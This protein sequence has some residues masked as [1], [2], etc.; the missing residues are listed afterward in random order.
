MYF[1]SLVAA[2]FLN[3][4]VLIYGPGGPAPVMKE[5]ALKF[6][7]KTKEKVVVTAGPTPSWFK[8]ARKDADL[9]FSGNT[10]MMDGF[11]KRIPSLN[12]EDLVVLNARP[13]GIIV[14]PN[15]P[16]NIKS[17]EDILK[18]N[19][20]VMV[21]DG[22]GQVGL[23]EDMALKDGKRE[24][25]VKLRKNIKVYAKNSKIAIDEWNNNP[26]I[27]TLIIWSHWAKVLGDKALFVED[28][29]A[30]VYCTAEIIPT[31]KGLQNK[32]ALEFVKFIQSKEAQKI[33]K[34][35]AWNEVE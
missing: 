33:W 6:E 7:E 28:E 19:V 13:S 34:K 11:I 9:I 27:D 32:Q 16:K 2:S 1:L 23:Y 14:R 30:A 35:H 24:N 26:N 10:S 4:E 17:F 20:N 12:L 18:D 3:A 31:K 5:L 29:K 15:N 21:V 22:A 25:L 8:K